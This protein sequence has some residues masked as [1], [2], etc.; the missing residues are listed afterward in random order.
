MLP[1]IVVS[2]QTLIENIITLYGP[3]PHGNVILDADEIC[4]KTRVQFH[5]SGRL[6]P[7]VIGS[8][9][10]LENSLADYAMARS[11]KEFSDAVT[12]V[13]DAILRLSINLKK[14]SR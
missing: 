4:W 3:F 1:E 9:H 12:A 10:L 8:L 2:I 5:I 6:T 13:R 14:P 11:R 7:A